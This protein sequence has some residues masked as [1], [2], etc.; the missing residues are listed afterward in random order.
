MDA[1]AEIE[2]KRHRD[3]L[4][5]SIRTMQNKIGQEQVGHVFDTSRLIKDNTSLIHEINDIRKEMANLDQ[6]DK[7]T[8]MKIVLKKEEDNSDTKLPALS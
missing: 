7:R 1:S 4:E 5:R 2:Y 6:V 8:G 3:Y